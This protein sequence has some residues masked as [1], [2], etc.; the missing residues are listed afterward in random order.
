MYM[1][2]LYRP[3]KGASTPLKPTVPFRERNEP[4]RE[5]DFISGLHVLR[6]SINSRV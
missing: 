2:V 1:Y 3:R 4:Y 6:L 5:P